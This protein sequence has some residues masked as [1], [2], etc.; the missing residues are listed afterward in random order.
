MR[1]NFIFLALRKRLKVI[2]KWP[3]ER[4]VSW[5]AP[6]IKRLYCPCPFQ[7][8]SLTSSSKPGLLTSCYSFFLLALQTLLITVSKLKKIPKRKKEIIQILTTHQL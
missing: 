6:N 7:G 3:I 4:F 5:G 2:S 8:F 1:M